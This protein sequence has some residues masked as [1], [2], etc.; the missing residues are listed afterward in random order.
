[1]E[2][3]ESTLTLCIVFSQI[4]HSHVRSLSLANPIFSL[5][6]G[7][8]LDLLGI[9]ILPPLYWGRGQGASGFPL[10]P[11]AARRSG[12]PASLMKCGNCYELA[13]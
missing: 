9:S 11:L 8:R 1:M 7:A 13:N 3:P 10:L 12:Y 6:G 2:E 4:A 5:N